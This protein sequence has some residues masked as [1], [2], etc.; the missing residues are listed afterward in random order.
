MHMD[1]SQKC[2]RRQSWLFLSSVVSSLEICK[3]G[4]GQITFYITDIPIWAV[5]GLSERNVSISLTEMGC[6][7]CLCI[8]TGQAMFCSN[9]KGDPDRICKDMMYQGRSSRFPLGRGSREDRLMRKQLW[10]REE[11][12]SLYRRSSSPLQAATKP[13]ILMIEAQASI[14][15][16]SGRW[17]VLHH[18][19]LE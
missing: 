9:V 5:H 18:L 11:P 17:H 15:P 13:I 4:G 12:S 6:L 10:R 14:W 1:E 3:R 7:P 2:R 19:G 16:M 8:G